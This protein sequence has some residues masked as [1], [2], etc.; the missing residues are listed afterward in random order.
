[1]DMKK[2]TRLHAAQPSDD[3]CLCS[4]YGHTGV[5]QGGVLGLFTGI[6]TSVV[7]CNFTANNSPASTGAALFTVTMT[8]VNVINNTFV[9]NTGWF[10]AVTCRWSSAV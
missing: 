1:M 7:G 8:A 6:T 3:A 10:L 2:P 4:F 9:G 5:G